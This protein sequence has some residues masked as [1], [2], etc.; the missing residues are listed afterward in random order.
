MGRE[1]GQKS[2]F[3]VF[4]EEGAKVGAEAGAKAGRKF[5]WK[6]GGDTGRKVGEE[7]GMKAGREAGYKV[8][9]AE[10]MT[11]FKIGI[12]K[13]RVMAL[14]ASLF[15]LTFFRMLFHE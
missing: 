5:G 11:M 4:G 3:E 12:S 10:A 8:G 14:K 15:R 9:H 1:S 2:G 6:I 13:E 7:L